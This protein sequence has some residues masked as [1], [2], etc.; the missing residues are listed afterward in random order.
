MRLHCESV[1]PADEHREVEA[2]RR[3]QAG[4]WV[5]GVGVELGAE[6]LPG[7]P[8]CLAG[9][10]TFDPGT[11]S[12][13]G[14]GPVGGVFDFAGE[15]PGLGGYGE[16]GVNGCISCHEERVGGGILKR[17]ANVG[18]AGRDHVEALKHTCRED[19]HLVDVRL[20][21]ECKPR[22]DVFTIPD[23]WGASCR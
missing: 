15:E 7:V 18:G 9:F 6:V 8:D 4:N 20:G 1:R 12:A 3:V 5:G 10:V 17:A 19:R 22:R 21:K 23:V 14:L 13:S 11:E 2:P 16:E